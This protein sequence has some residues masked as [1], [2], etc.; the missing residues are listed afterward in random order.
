MLT[1]NY[2]TAESLRGL[3][4]M[5]IKT[6]AQVGAELTFFDISQYDDNG[7]KRW[8]AWYWNRSKFEDE[9]NE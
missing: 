5:M 6:Q 3:R 8:V 4:L 9:V 7:K 2:I 1:P